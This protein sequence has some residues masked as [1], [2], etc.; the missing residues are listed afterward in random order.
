MACRVSTPATVGPLAAALRQA[1]AVHQPPTAAALW[2]PPTGHLGADAS[3]IEA[4]AAFF[5]APSRHVDAA[6]GDATALRRESVLG[7]TAPLLKAWLRE[8]GRSPSSSRRLAFDTTI[9]VAPRL[10]RRAEVSMLPTN[11]AAPRLELGVAPSSSGRD[12]LVLLPRCV[13]AKSRGVKT[14]IVTALTRPSGE[15][16]GLPPGVGASPSGARGASAV[17]V[18]CHTRVKT[19]RRV[20]LRDL[21]REEEEDGMALIAAD[22]MSPLVRYWESLHGAATAAHL[23]RA[24]FFLDLRVR[25]RRSFVLPGDANVRVDVTAVDS[26]RVPTSVTAPPIAAASLLRRVA[27]DMIAARDVV[28][29]VSAMPAWIDALERSPS[30]VAHVGPQ[31]TWEMELELVDSRA[32]VAAAGAEA[33]ASKL[34]AA[35]DRMLRDLDVAAGRT[36]YGRGIRVRQAPLDGVDQTGGR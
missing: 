1:A 22:V 20:G 10:H 2:W 13:T 31:R 24:V 29:C 8:Y 35:A 34:A 36:R 30:S 16:F 28:P 26:T 7:L 14:P 33:A 6:G 11:A 9:H 12:G 5:L 3:H 4:E 25:H 17:S 32:V 27:P 23:R 19:E 15:G 21:F 18:C